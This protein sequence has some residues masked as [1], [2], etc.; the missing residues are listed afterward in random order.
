MLYSAPNLI[1]PR[2]SLVIAPALNCEK[3]WPTT[4]MLMKTQVE[5]RSFKFPPYEGEEEK[6][7]PGVWG[8]RLAEYWAQKL[9]ATGIVTD[10]IIA[11]DWGWYVP[12][13]IDGVRLAVCCGHQDGDTD[14][15]LSFTEP[16]KPILRKW[17][18]KVDIS[19]PLTRLTSA[20]RTILEA[21]PDIT[22]VVW[23]E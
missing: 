14:E 22:D 21:D 3:K 23:R 12:L 5:F 20:M 8:K 17:F 10:E 2:T 16:S 13:F 11:E 6:I 19:E 18:R 4:L 9:A 15:F 1:V 7:N